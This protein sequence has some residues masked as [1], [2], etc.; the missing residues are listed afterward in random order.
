ME[1]SPLV[2]ILILFGALLSAT[3]QALFKIGMSNPVIQTSL[4][5]GDMWAVAITA[6]T[7]PWLIGG[8]LVYGFSVIVWLLALARV[9]VSYAYPF[10]ALGMVV[11]TLCGRFLLN[12]SLPVL[13]IVGLAVI[14]LGVMIVAQSYSPPTRSVPQHGD[15]TR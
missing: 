12:E 4:Q 11:T 1:V 5:L 14:V 7:S 8:I 3:G 13:R 6:L 10:A 15:A 9:D 2:I